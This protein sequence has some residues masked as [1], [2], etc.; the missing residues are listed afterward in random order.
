MTLNLS[1]RGYDCISDSIVSI[2]LSTALSVAFL[3]FQA[4]YLCVV[5][6]HEG[7]DCRTKTVNTLTTLLTYFF[8]HNT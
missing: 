1:H 4:C 8:D 6:V 7:I 5:D 3:C 2:S